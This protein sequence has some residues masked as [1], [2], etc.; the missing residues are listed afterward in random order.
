VHALVPVSMNR[1]LIA[2]SLLIICWCSAISAQTSDKSGEFWPTLD[3][4]T[5]LRSGLQIEAF[6]GSERSTDFPYRQLF[7]GAEFGYHRNRITKAHAVNIDPD[8]EHQLQFTGGYEYLRTIQSGDA[9][10]EDRLTLQAFLRQRF[11][12]SF[13]VTDRNRVEFRWVNDVYSTRY[14]NMLTLEHDCLI[15]HLRFTPYAAAEVYYDGGKRSWNEEQYSAGVQ[16][17]YKRLWM[18]NTYYLRQHCTTC[19]PKYL[20]VAAVALNFYFRS[21]R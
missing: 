16:W 15:Q 19:S 14:R 20:D 12:P 1:A 18:L 13:L 4:H 6:V 2:V 5:Q 10:G 9:K 3:F 8:K 17:P 21:D 7:G 11:G